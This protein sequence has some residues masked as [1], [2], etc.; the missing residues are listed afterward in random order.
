MPPRKA[1]GMK[2]GRIW[3]PNP[4]APGF[5]EKAERQT[6][7]LRGAPEESETLDFIETAMA[8]LDDPLA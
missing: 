5:R 6:A 7:L 3:M 4:R 8:D 2:Q 1:K